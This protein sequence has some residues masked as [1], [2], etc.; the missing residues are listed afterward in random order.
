M[1]TD[2]E[3]QWV[4]AVE[5]AEDEKENLNLPDLR[6]QAEWTAE[7][8]LRKSIQSLVE[9]GYSYVG[10]MELVTDALRTTCP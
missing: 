3:N 2:S 10:I 6:E 9:L 7:Q 5:W 1:D 8:G 4:R